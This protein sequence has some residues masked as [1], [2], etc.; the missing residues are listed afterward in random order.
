MSVTIENPWVGLLTFNVMGMIVV[1][2]IIFLGNW[3][4]KKR[5]I[6]S[7]PIMAIIVPVLLLLAV[8]AN[9]VAIIAIMKSS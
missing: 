3:W 4:D 2:L 5:G 8:P 7:L 1:L 9:L 6:T